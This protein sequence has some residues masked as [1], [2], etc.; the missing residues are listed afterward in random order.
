MVKKDFSDSTASCILR[1]QAVLQSLKPVERRTA[2][3][4]LR[5]PQDVLSSTII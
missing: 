5:N 2:D 3:Y 4:I 1:L